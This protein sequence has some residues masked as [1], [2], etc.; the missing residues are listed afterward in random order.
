M[1]ADKSPTKKATRRRRAPYSDEIPPE[2]SA[3]TSSS[4]EN[5]V[6]SV[7]Q[8][9]QSSRLTTDEWYKA[10]RTT[11]AYANYVKAGK[12]W[13]EDWVTEARD[14]G[15]AN[16][17]TGEERTAFRAAFD[18]IGAN[19]PTAL[20]LYTAYKCEHQS[21]GFSTADGVRSAFKQYFEL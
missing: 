2:L 14:D 6:P 19:T 13:L 5:E 11:K 3:E 17:G 18:V 1:P 7:T 20:R 10:A 8:L 16:R 12:K 21:C 4:I 15:N 9:L